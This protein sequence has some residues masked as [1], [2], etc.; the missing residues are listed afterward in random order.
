MALASCLLATLLGCMFTFVLS[1]KAAGHD[2]AKVLLSANRLERLVADLETEKLGFVATGDRKTLQPWRAANAAFAHEAVTLQRLAADS[3]PAQARLARQIVQSANSYIREHAEPVV[4]LAERDPRTARTVIAR[5][6][7]RRRINAI[8]SQFDRFLEV[9]HRITAAHERGA[10]PEVRRVIAEAGGA[11]GS[12]LVLFLLVGYMTRANVWPVRRRVR[13]GASLAPFPSLVRESGRETDRLQWILE[14]ERA[15]RRIAALVAHGGAPPGLLGAVAGEVGALLGAEYTIIDRYDPGGTLATVARWSAS[16]VAGPPPGARRPVENGSIEDVVLRTERA[17]RAAATDESGPAGGLIG[18]WARAHDLGQLVCCAIMAGEEVWGTLTVLLRSAD[19]PAEGAEHL[20]SEFAG[21]TGTA[22]VRAEEHAALLA[23][24]AR[25]VGA[26]DAERRRIER[27]LHDHAQ[28]RLVSLALE[29]RTIEAGIPAGRHRLREHLA[30]A[31][32]G[33]SAITEELQDV[34]RE[35]YPPMIARGGLGAALRALGRRSRIPVEFDITGES[36]PERVALTVYRIVDEA[37][38][39]AASYARATLVQVELR[40]RDGYARFALRDDGVGG[41]GPRP[42]S[43][44]SRLI[45]RV[46]AV[47]GSM[48]VDSPAGGGTTVRAAIPIHGDLSAS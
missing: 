43:G 25:L 29:L 4:R 10:V 33:L 23:S 36:V 13:H 35:L 12:F 6:E 9:Q 7:G 8:R 30:D 3:G 28:Q 22:I 15:L 39:N 27:K 16:G 14:E 19:P 44:L 46:E 47:G 5:G 45:D 42:G 21:L 32:R 48:L 24:R 18:S 31:A 20:M 38:T 1:S 34:A 40:I 41:A 11:A 37:L 2:S 26:A 17:T